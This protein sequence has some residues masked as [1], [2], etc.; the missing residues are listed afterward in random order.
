[1]GRGRYKLA[2]LVVEM[3]DARRE[4]ASPHGRVRLVGPEWGH[5]LDRW[6][7][8]YAVYIVRHEVM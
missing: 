8:K 1:M 3:A 2:D 6:R 4:V 5:R 7:G